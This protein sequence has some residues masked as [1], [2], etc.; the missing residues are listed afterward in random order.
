[1]A[2]LIDYSAADMEI[3]SVLGNQ[4]TCPTCFMITF[5]LLWSF[6]TE[7]QNLLSL[8]ARVFFSTVE[9][10]GGSHQPTNRH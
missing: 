5:I 3:F 6:G 1:M 2:H 10:S 7:P 4:K 9:K 8:H